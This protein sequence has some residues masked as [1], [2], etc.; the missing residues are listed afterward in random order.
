MVQ[1]ETFV[2]YFVLTANVTRPHVYVQCTTQPVEMH[3]AYTRIIIPRYHKWRHARY[4]ACVSIHGAALKIC[5]RHHMQH[6]KAPVSFRSG[7]STLPPTAGGAVLQSPW[8]LLDCPSLLSLPINLW[9]FQTW[10][11]R[12]HQLQCKQMS[13]SH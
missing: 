8:G 3:V 10:K 4:M 13:D 5:F 1:L 6:I 7:G 9:N 12:H 2:R 11:F